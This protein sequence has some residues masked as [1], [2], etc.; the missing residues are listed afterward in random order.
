M[1]E[2]QWFINVTKFSANPSRALEAAQEQP[3]LITKH[4]RPHAYLVSAE[5]WIEMCTLLAHNRAEQAENR[6]AVDPVGRV[7]INSA[8]C[9]NG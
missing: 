3:V 4:Q 1:T 6:Y 9:H 7:G 5:C 8:S 2:S